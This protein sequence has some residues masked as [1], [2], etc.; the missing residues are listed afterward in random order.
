M[1]VPVKRAILEPA[2]GYPGDDLDEFR[3]LHL[4]TRREP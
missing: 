2:Y 1:E 4:A 3:R